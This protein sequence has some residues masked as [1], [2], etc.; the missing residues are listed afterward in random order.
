MAF[1]TTELSVLTNPTFA[2]IV[3]DAILGVEINYEGMKSLEDLA[4][5][6]INRHEFAPVKDEV[7]ISNTALR[8]INKS[9]V[10]V[11]GTVEVDPKDLATITE[12]YKLPGEIIISFDLKSFKGY[13][14]NITQ[15]SSHGY[16]PTR[17]LGTMVGNKLQ[18]SSEL[19]KAINESETAELRERNEQKRNKVRDF[20][21]GPSVFAEIGNLSVVAY[22]PE[23]LV[24]AESAFSAYEQGLMMG[25]LGSKEHI[26]INQ[27]KFFVI[28]E[29]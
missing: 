18:L 8:R 24:R 27:L 20:L 4:R 15:I 29:P 26:N 7:V 17:F 1:D 5:P 25:L 19:I 13:E 10:D 12:V 23:K 11:N 14:W 21:R 22:N 2:G 16:I 6:M 3:S 9:N 28:S